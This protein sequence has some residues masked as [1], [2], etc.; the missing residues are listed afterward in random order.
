MNTLRM[1]AAQTLL[2][3]AH[4]IDTNSTFS[5]WVEILRNWLSTLQNCYFE[6][7]EFFWFV[8][9]RIICDSWLCLEFPQ[10]ETGQNLLYKASN[11][12]R[13][14]T[15]LLEN[16]LQSLNKSVESE[17]QSE[18]REIDNKQ[19][20]NELWSNLAAYMNSEILYTLKRLLPAD[21]KVK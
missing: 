18:K 9:H 5:K 21:L 7:T 1:P 13:T 14:W 15:K 8:I 6:F 11:L 4:S 19:L 10:P 2:L 20:E 16:K 3:F 12:R 17:L